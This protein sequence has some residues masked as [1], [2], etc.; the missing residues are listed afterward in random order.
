VPPLN[1]SEVTRDDNQWTFNP[2][3]S[4]EDTPPPIN[5]GGN[6]STFF[7]DEQTTLNNH[8]FSMSK[9]VDNQSFD[10]MS[11][12]TGGQSSGDFSGLFGTSSNQNNNDGGLF[13]LFGASNPSSDNQVKGIMR[14]CVC[15]NN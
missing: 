7:T 9:P 13:S 10:F 6:I 4:I 5:D 3:T 1:P 14:L 11:S 15:I 2:S 8:L 12:F